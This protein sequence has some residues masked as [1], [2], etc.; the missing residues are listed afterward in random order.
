MK[1]LSTQ[2]GHKGGQDYRPNYYCPTCHAYNR[3][4]HEKGCVD[5]K[6]S[7]CGT[8]RLPSK[9]ADKK[10]WQDFYE[11]FVLKNDIK[12]IQTLKKS[13]KSKSYRESSRYE[14]LQEDERYLKMS[15]D[16]LLKREKFLKMTKQTDKLK[17]CQKFLTALKRKQH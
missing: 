7:I 13:K 14:I 6:V 1:K 12:Y 5:V 15:L 16:E 9:N 2:Q 4:P 8:A 11:K 10:V 3:I 17:K